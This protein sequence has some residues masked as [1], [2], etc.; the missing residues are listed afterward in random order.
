MGKESAALP[1]RPRTACRTA[2]T[3]CRTSPLVLTGYCFISCLTLTLP[4]PLT[5][6]PHKSSCQREYCLSLASPALTKTSNTDRGKP[7]IAPPRAE[8]A[9]PDLFA[10]VSI[11]QGSTCFLAFACQGGIHWLAG[12]QAETSIQHHGKSTTD[13][14]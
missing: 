1:K 10:R 5:F 12:S 2:C 6:P 8:F 9:V 7:L 14:T 11:P 13:G 3:A 4:G